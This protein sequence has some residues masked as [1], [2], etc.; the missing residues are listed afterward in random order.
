M[1][2][3][4]FICILVE[5]NRYF[6]DLFEVEVELVLGYNVEYLV[7]G[8][9]F[10]FLV[11]Y[12]NIILMCML[13]VFFFL[14]GWYFLFNLIFILGIIWLVLKLLIFVYMFVIVRGILL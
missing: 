4:F 12:S 9:V 2:I 7:M 1:F 10:F 13:S 8:F 14:G 5:I 3:F 6:F 11:E